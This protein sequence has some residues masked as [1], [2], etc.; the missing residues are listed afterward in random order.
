MQALLLRW[1]QG[2]VHLWGTRHSTWTTSNGEHP[3]QALWGKVAIRCGH[4]NPHFQ[5]TLRTCRQMLYWVLE[6]QAKVKLA[7]FSSDIPEM[8]AARSLR[9]YHSA[10]W[11]TLR[12]KFSL[13]H[14]I[15]SHEAWIQTS[16]Q[17]IYFSSALSVHCK[18]YSGSSVYHSG[19]T[20]TLND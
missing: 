18:R 5:R 15:L 7:L 14:P 10:R 6:M 9:T 3:N 11:T 17:V 16:I 12:P 1:S 2:W 8:L 13:L 4:S 19:T 20:K